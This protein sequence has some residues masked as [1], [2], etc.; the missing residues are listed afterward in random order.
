MFEFQPK[1]TC[2]FLRVMSGLL[3]TSA[4]DQRLASSCASVAAASGVSASLGIG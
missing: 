3:A 4:R 2:E 1:L